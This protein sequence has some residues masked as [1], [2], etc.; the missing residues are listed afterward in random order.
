[1][2]VV[3]QTIYQKQRLEEARKDL[4]NMQNTFN[5]VLANPSYDDQMN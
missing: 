4:R 2:D 5:S 3:P 1:V